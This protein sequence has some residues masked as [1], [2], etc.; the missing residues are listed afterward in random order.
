M[1][2]KD[3]EKLLLV[4]YSTHNSF[5]PVMADNEKLLRNPCGVERNPENFVD[6]IFTGIFVLIYDRNKSF[7]QKKFGMR[8]FF[9]Y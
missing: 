8:E 5:V 7:L 2:K 6:P 1:R 9:M 4:R 3:A